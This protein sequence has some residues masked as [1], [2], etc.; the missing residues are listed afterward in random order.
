MDL[1]PE[2]TVIT[3]HGRANVACACQE[4]RNRLSAMVT[5]SEGFAGLPDDPEANE[6]EPKQ[7]LLGCAL[8]VPVRGDQVPYTGVDRDREVWRSARTVGGSWNACFTCNLFFRAES[9]SER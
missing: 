5:V 6:A 2:T 8:R 7:R 1:Q 4:R 9:P 3:P